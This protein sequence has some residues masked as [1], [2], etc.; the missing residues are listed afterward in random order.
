VGAVDD[1]AAAL[2]ERGDSDCSRRGQRPR[3]KRQ[4]QVSYSFRQKINRPFGFSWTG[5][6]HPRKPQLQLLDSLG[7]PWILSSESRL[8]NGLRGISREIFFAALLSRRAAGTGDAPVEVMR[9]HRIIHEASLAKFLL[10]V[11]RLSTPGS[12]LA[13]PEGRAD[14]PLDSLRFGSDCRGSKARTTRFALIRPC[15]P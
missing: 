8:I 7:F 15:R 14:H 2:N 6:L 4:A 9:M 12:V 10:F 5:R 3:L 13:G 1:R 11:N